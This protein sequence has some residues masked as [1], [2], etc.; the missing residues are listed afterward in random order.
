M[1]SCHA[2]K[3]RGLARL[4]GQVHEHHNSPARLQ[5]PSWPRTGGSGNPALVGAPQSS[6]WRGTFTFALPRENVQ[7]FNAYSP[8][9]RG[10]TCDTNNSNSSGLHRLCQNYTPPHSSLWGR[11]HWQAGQYIEIC[12]LST[13]PPVP[14]AMQAKG[15]I[16]QGT[17]TGLEG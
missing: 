2:M 4:V 13:T 6:T 7:C 1:Q 16:D 12:T 11:C 10:V 14:C 8:C 3:F 17:S 9:L 15:K 5:E